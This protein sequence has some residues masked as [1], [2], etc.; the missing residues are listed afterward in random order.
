[1]PETLLER[2]SDYIAES[3]QKASRE[4]CAAANA[5]EDAIDDGIGAAKRVAKRGRAAAGDFLQDTARQ[6]K[7][8]RTK[9]VAVTFAAGL[10]AGIL[11]SWVAR[12]R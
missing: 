12:R 9:T 7:Q 1:M 4:T 10:S 8:H 2:A 6:V 11:I 3:A 5:I